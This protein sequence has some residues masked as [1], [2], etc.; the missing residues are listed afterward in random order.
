MSPR[1]YSM[2]RRRVA[3]GRT[4]ER[5]LAAVRHLLA[6]GGVAR[7]SID[8]VARAAD[9]A[10]GTVYQQFGSRDRLLAAVFAVPV[11]RSAPS[12]IAIWARE[13]DPERALV[14]LVETFCRMWALDRRMLRGL[15][16]RPEVR[17]RER[18][19]ARL[20][21]RLVA[22]LSERGL[23]RRGWSNDQARDLVLLATSFSTFDQLR[24]V[25]GR[26]D[27]TTTAA[28]L[29]LVGQVVRLRRPGG[30]PRTGRAGGTAA[31]R[32]TRSSPSGRS[33]SRGSS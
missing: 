17:Q 6:R 28:I 13:P 7:L 20:I 22:R 5:I 16:G 31:P 12:P 14:G 24:E 30:L 33:R 1:P 29:A 4:R 27:A 15:Q 25:A 2:E 8:A 26:T 3:S 32:S 21:D 23:L 18:A 10:R 11:D 19:R 9:V